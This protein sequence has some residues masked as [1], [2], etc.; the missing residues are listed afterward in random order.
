LFSVA[1]SH[2]LDGSLHLPHCGPAR[3]HFGKVP[4]P[5]SEIPS[6]HPVANIE[7]E[8]MIRQKGGDLVSDTWKVVHEV[9]SPVAHVLREFVI[10]LGSFVPASSVEHHI[11]QYHT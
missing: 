11:E 6:A 7:A 8:D 5:L 3:N 10:V 2:F 1:A 4:D 9:S